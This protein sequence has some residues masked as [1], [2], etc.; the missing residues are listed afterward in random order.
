MVFFILLI[1]VV[2]DASPKN[3]K[4]HFIFLS[5]RISSSV[6][7]LRS[8]QIVSWTDSDLDQESAAFS[9]PAAPAQPLL[10]FF[11]Y[12]YHLSLHSGDCHWKLHSNFSFTLKYSLYKN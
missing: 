8:S 3:F 5:T 9:F 1:G 4:T 6:P 2:K 12:F 7:C 10:F 11:H